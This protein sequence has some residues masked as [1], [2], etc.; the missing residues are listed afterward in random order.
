MDLLAKNQGVY[1]RPLDKG[2]RYDAGDKLGFLQ[3]N[4][5]LGLR[6]PELGDNLKKYLKTLVAGLD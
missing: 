5:E 3:A 6:H 2:N 4:I 1:V